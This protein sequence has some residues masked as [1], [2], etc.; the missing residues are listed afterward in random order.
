MF[1][2]R[3]KIYMGKSTCTSIYDEQVSIMAFLNNFIRISSIC[4][5]AMLFGNSMRRIVMMIIKNS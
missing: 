5:S 1:L 2:V 3:F 4:I